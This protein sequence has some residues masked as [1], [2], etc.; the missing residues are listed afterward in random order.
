MKTPRASVRAP[1]ATARLGFDSYSVGDV[2]TPAPIVVRPDELLRG[3]AEL[4]SQH[5][6]SGLPVVE[7][8]G[9]IVGVLSSKDVL[10]VLHER[11]GLTVPLGIFDLLLEAGES[12]R[13]HLLASSRAT[14]SGVRVADAMSRPAVTIGAEESIDEAI[15][16]MLARRI[17]RLPV[18][19]K[20]QLIGIVTRHDLLTTLGAASATPDP[21]LG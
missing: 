17:N 7:P 19:R 18:V 20:G 2:M 1:T 5:G 21:V 10:R 15:R 6:V 12:R 4:M 16:R 3:A 8:G 14:L 11:A 9:A 13:A